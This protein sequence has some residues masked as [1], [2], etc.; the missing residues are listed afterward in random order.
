MITDSNP[1]SNSNPNRNRSP[2]NVQ[3]EI[4]I[5][6]TPV[7]EEEVTVK[8]EINDDL[9]LPLA[10]LGRIVPEPELVPESTMEIE[11]IDTGY[12]DKEVKKENF[13]IAENISNSDD[14]EIM[15]FQVLP[16]GYIV[17]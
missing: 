10:L 5:E 12:S 7:E 1:N 14:A 8:V 4:C 15:N 6:T 2:E 17:S 3:E 16:L 13:Y 11:T 9:P